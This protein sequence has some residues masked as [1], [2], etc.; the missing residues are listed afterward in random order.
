MISL[1]LCLIYQPKPT[2]FSCVEQYIQ[3]ILTEMIVTF[4]KR[5]MKADYFILALNGRQ[6]SYVANL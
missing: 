2:R 4:S 5:E 6:Y 3:L 1:T